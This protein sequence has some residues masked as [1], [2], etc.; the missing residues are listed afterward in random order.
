MQGIFVHDQNYCKIREHG[1]FN[2]YFIFIVPTKLGMASPS[3][4]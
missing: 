1:V 3:V 2:F 4:L